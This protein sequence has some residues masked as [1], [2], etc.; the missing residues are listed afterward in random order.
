MSSR[1]TYVH[2][3]AVDV[4]ELFEAEQA[5]TVGAVIEHIALPR[6]LT[7]MVGMMQS[8]RISTVVA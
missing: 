4:P 5:R 7:T 2:N 6:M 3:P 8:R 1:I